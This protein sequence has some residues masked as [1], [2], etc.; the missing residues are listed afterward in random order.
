MVI[1]SYLYKQVSFDIIVHRSYVGQIKWIDN[2]KSK[3]NDDKENN[4]QC[5][6]ACT[7]IKQKLK[8]I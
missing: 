3:S 4:Y 7:I 6:L 5:Q 8:K 1:Y 2:G